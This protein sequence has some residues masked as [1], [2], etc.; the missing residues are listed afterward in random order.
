MLLAFAIV[1][2]PQSEISADLT[3]ANLSGALDPHYVNQT[4]DTMSGDLTLNS[5]LLLTNLANISGNF[6][7]TNENGQIVDTGFSIT[8]VANISSNLQTQIDN[9]DNTYATDTNLA[10]ISGN[11]QSQIDNFDNT[12]TLQFFKVFIHYLFLLILLI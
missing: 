6:L 12:Y 3:Y 7:T 5:N 11:L 10:N 9:L 1:Y 4:G 2:T 8:S